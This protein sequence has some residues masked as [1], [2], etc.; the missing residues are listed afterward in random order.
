MK[1]MN[2]K[3]QE[4][5]VDIVSH[6]GKTLTALRARD[7]VKFTIPIANLIP[8]HQEEVRKLPFSDSASAS[9]DKY[10]LEEIVESSDENA[11]RKLIRKLD[12]LIDPERGPYG[13]LWGSPP[14]KIVS[15]LGKPRSVTAVAD[16]IHVL[17]YGKTHRFYFED[18]KLTALSIKSRSYSSTDSYLFN[19]SD[20]SENPF[21]DTE[22][23][24]EI[25]TDKESIRWGMSEEIIKEKIGKSLNDYTEGRYSSS[26][27]KYF[28]K[29][30]AKV[31]IY[32]SN[33]S[34]KSN[35][36]TTEILIEGP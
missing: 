10:R 2:I 17:L 34:S 13:I 15:K 11:K 21:F 9:L 6:D 14:E 16:E 7:G 23:L 20:S 22:S 5:I 31:I 19:K 26:S 4:I 36:T 18:N 12:S 24:I 8:A 30:S 32:F 33:S 25:I 27:Q 35:Y 3:G 1:L 28:K 29:G